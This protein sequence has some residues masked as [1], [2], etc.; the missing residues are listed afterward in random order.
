MLRMRS[1]KVAPL[2]PFFTQPS[3]AHK[4]IIHFE[5]NSQE[6]DNKSTCKLKKNEFVEPGDH[7]NLKREYKLDDMD[8][9]RLEKE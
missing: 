3:S 2:D 8:G 6:D 9:V 4:P 7:S 5:N 1:S